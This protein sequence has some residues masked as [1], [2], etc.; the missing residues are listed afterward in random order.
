VPVRDKVQWQ[1]QQDA[2]A[3]PMTAIATDSE[4]SDQKLRRRKPAPEVYQFLVRL[5][6]AAYIVFIPAKPADRHNEGD[7]DSKTF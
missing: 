6:T 2:D 3:T 1:L 5:A 4:R 7:E